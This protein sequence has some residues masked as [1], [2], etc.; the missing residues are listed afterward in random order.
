[1]SNYN[2]DDNNEGNLFVESDTDGDGVADAIFTE[3][4]T[5]GDGI[6]DTIYGEIDTN[7][8]NFT[9]TSVYG[10]D[11][12]GDGFVDTLDRL[13]LSRHLANWAG[14]ENLSYAS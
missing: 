1:M 10:Q 6:T 2:Y 7:G 14:Y 4:D 3:T 8:D 11:I 5:D 12:N 9:D 13:I